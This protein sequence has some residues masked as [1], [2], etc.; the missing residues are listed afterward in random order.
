MSRYNVREK[1]E[2]YKAEPE[3]LVKAILGTISKGDMQVTVTH[4]D[5]VLI[6]DR[7]SRGQ[8][9]CVGEN[10]EVTFELEVKVVK[11][12]KTR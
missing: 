12:V 10:A 2:Q 8:Y 1:L 4:N 9:I 6:L 11:V 5:Q 3:A 7:T